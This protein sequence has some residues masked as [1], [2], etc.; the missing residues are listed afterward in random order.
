MKKDFNQ[1]KILLLAVFLLIS[2]V[3]W[4]VLGN[5]PVNFNDQQPWIYLITFTVLAVAI[6]IAFDSNHKK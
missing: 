4:I 3:L 6:F 5:I 2:P 1:I